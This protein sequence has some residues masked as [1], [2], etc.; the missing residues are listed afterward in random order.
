MKKKI[1]IAALCLCSLFTLCGCGNSGN[2]TETNVYALIDGCDAD[3]YEWISPDG[4]HYWI[5]I[6]LYRMSMAPRYDKSGNLVID[7]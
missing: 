7:K 3:F 1:L 4:V 6:G 5:S 2:I